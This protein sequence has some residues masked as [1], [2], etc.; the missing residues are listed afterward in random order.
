MEK[1]QYRKFWAAAQIP[2]WLFIIMACSLGQIQGDDAVTE[3]RIP[4]EIEDSGFVEYN[5]IPQIGSGEENLFIRLSDGQAQFQETTPISMAESKPLTPEEI[6][7]ILSRL[8]AFESEPEDQIDFRIPDEVLPPPRTGDSISEP[9]PLEPIDFPT[10]ISSDGPLEV[11][12]FSPEGEIPI[13]PFVNVTFN[14][15]MVPLTTIE[16]LTNEEVPV[17]IEP[18]IPGTWRWLGTKTLNFQS[19][20]EQMDRLPMA[21]AYQV[22]IPAGI[23]SATLG[24]TSWKKVLNSP[25]VHPLRQYK[26]ITHQ[27]VP[28]LW[29][30]FSSSPSTSGSILRLY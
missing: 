21:T 24:R 11:L 29:I 22:T 28:N 26:P 16:D 1:R 4:L 10:D 18:S 5:S 27:T 14:H 9:F 15:P 12:R 25:S 20:S 8:P 7:L 19:D 30:P 17:N 6:D 3:Q 13:A 23:K 2:L